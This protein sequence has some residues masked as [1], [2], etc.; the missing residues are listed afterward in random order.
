MFEQSILLPGRDGKKPWTFAVSILV[1]VSAVSVLLLAPLVYT[2]HLGQGL[3][4]SMHISPP[5][6]KPIALQVEPTVVRPAAR[7][8]N[9]LAVPRHIRPLVEV[10]R[11]IDDPPP[12]ECMNCVVGAPSIDGVNDTIGVIGPITVGP[13]LPKPQPKPVEVKKVAEP[14]P[15]GPIRVSLG[16]QEA[17]IIRRVVPTYPPLARTA[18]VQG[19]VRLLGVINAEGRIEQLKVI[20]GHP[21]L[22]QAAVDAVKQWLYRP[23]LLS[24]QPVEVSAPIEVNFILSN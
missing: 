2:E 22:V 13:P 21:L 11:T 6:P 18:R 4:Q 15:S 3:I 14:P 12:A 23:T 1:E 24:G 8:F 9:P 7:V 17:R 20:S 19:T 16:A 5:M 10:L